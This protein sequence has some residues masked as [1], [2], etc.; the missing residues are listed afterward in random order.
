MR[1]GDDLE[2]RFVMPLKK[3]GHEKRRRVAAEITR[4]ITDFELSRARKI[5]PPVLERR[6]LEIFSK[7]VRGAHLQQCVCAHAEDRERVYRFA[8]AS[9]KRLRISASSASMPSQS[10]ICRRL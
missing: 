8:A 2:T 10:Q 5:F 7:G 3:L 1:I 4:E 6:G 9:A